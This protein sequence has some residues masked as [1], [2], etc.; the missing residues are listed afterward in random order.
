MHGKA[1]SAADNG[2]AY[3]ISWRKDKTAHGLK[4]T[5]GRERQRLPPRKPLD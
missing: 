1:L 2:Y 5:S 3:G 4:P